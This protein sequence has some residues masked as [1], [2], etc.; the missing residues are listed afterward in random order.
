MNINAE[1]M[2]FVMAFNEEQHEQNVEEQ[3]QHIYNDYKNY[4]KEELLN[5]IVEIKLNLQ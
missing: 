2:A 3:R 5:I 4:S 1:E